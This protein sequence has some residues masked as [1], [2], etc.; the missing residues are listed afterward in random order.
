MKHLKSDI[1][2]ILLGS[3]LMFLSIMFSFASK[4]YEAKVMGNAAYGVGVYAPEKDSPEWKG[5]ASLRSKADGVFYLSILFGICAICPGTVVAFRKSN[6]RNKYKI[7]QLHPAGTDA[8][9]IGEK[10]SIFGIVGTFIYI[11]VIVFI[12]WSSFPKLATMPL[13]EFGDFCAGVFGPLAIF[14]LILGFFQQGRELQQSTKALELQA[15]ELN[16]SVQQQKELVEVSREQVEAA[17]KALQYE[18]QKQIDSAKPV[19]VFS[20]VGGSYDGSRVRT[21]EKIAINT[22]GPVTQVKLTKE[23][24]PFTIDDIPLW[25][26]QDQ[27]KLKWKYA[28]NMPV[29]ESLQI[30]FTDKFGNTGD[31]QYKIVVNVRETPPTAEILSQ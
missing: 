14:W 20:D 4:H 29:E 1:S 25:G 24:N 27:I 10:L 11:G 15:A 30:Q 26:T 17:L 31:K 7:Q 16:N 8:S 28:K 13:N 6:E 19:F 22:G 23:G 21:F 9:G 3:I 18:Q 5:K 2:L 12:R